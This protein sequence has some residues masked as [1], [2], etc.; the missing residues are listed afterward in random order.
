MLMLWIVGAIV[1]MLMLAQLNIWIKTFF[2][3]PRHP[4]HR[5]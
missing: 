2:D 3:H 1:A 5:G 4:F